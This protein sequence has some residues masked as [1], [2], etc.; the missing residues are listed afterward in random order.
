[1]GKSAAATL[2][3]RWGIPVVD[4]DEVAREV[5]APGQSALAEVREVFGA[6][7]I[8]ADGSLNREWMA[9]RVFGDDAARGRLEAILHPRIRA[10]WEARVKEWQGAGVAVGAVVI[11]L[12]FETHAEDRFD[13]TICLACRPE[14]QRGRLAERGWSPDHVARRVAAQMP[15]EEK[16]RRATV[17]IWTETP[18]AEQSAQW[19]LVLARWGFVLGDE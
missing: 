10:V 8:R 5:V 3:Q 19:R 17:V 4:T 11:P 14:S 12:L 15:I 16:I 2:L 1:M 13:A 6:E 18:Q 9:G 7:A